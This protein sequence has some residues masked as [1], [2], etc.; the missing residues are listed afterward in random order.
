[1]IIEPCPHGLEELGISTLPRTPGLHISEIY[2]DLYQRLEPTRYKGGEPDPLHLE[3]GLAW[4]Q[5]LEEGLKRRLSANRP[6][7]LISPEGIY[8]SPD[9]IIANCAVRVGEIKL[10]WMSCREMPLER[11]THMPEKFSKWFVQMM[12]YCHI[13]ETPY[14]RLIG[15]FVNGDYP[16]GAPRPR[17][18]AWDLQF[19]SRELTDNWR[20]LMNHAKVMGVL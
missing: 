20:M 9:L 14:A 18:L 15:F 5:M 16:R 13:L 11:T 19:T 2:G 1:M 3:A 12:A 4:E 10:T 17:L 6:G 8:L 7:E